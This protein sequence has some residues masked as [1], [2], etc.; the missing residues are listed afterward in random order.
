MAPL[1]PGTALMGDG[2]HPYVS[3]RSWTNL[4]IAH[5]C[6]HGSRRAR[7]RG[8]H[9]LTQTPTPQSRARTI[10]PKCRHSLMQYQFERIGGGAAPSASASGP[11]LRCSLRQRQAQT[12]MLALFFTRGT[13]IIHKTV[14]ECL[15][16]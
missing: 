2:E 15:Y 16:C 7:H 3:T 4:R 14:V 8:A 5:L 1:R 13:I 10:R 12:L 6:A 11:G 9:F